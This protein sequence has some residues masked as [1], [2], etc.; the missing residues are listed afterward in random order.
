M[1]YKTNYTIFTHLYV[2]NQNELLILNPKFIKQ[3][4]TL[5]CFH[6]IHSLYYYNMQL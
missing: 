4:L 3:Y 5:L 1:N 2:S 6:I